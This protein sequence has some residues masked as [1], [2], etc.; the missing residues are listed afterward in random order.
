MGEDHGQDQVQDQGQ[1][2]D[3][4]QK[5]KHLCMDCGQTIIECI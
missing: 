5:N 1:D 4:D 2:Q 3:Q